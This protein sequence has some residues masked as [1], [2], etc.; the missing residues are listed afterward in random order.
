MVSVLVLGLCIGEIVNMHA[1]L[2]ILMGG[3]IL[4]VGFFLTYMSSH[5]VSEKKLGRRIP[6]PW[7]KKPPKV[8]DKSDIKYRDGDNT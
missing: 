6:L 2:E 7:E 1:I 8:F 5:M 3:A 4:F